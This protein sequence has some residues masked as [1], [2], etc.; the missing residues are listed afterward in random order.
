MRAIYKREL[1]SYFHS[2]IGFLFI[3]VTLF[4]LGLYFTVYNLMYGTPYF[5]YVV[6]SVIFLFLV[7]VPVL[8]MKILAEE[9]K[10]KT[11]QM[12]LTAPVTVGG[13]VMGKYLALLTIFAIPSVII[14]FYPLILTGFGTVPLGEAYLAILGFFLY[15]AA[16]IAIGL[17]IS[18]LT[19]SQ[20][21]AAV[22]TFAVLFLGYMMSSIS[23]LI[24]ST[25]NLLTKLL[26]CLDMYTPFSK[27]LN[28]TLNVGAV[29][30]FVSVIALVLF[31]TTQSIQKR[32]YSVSVKSLS[33]GAYNTGIIA[34]AV[35]VVVVVNIILGEMPGT[36]TA[37]DLTSEKLYSLT[38]QTKEFVKN[39]TEDVTI[40]VLVKEENE[41]TTLGQTLD[42]Y[43]DLSDHI[44]VEYVDPIVNPRFYTQFTDTAISTNS[45]IVVGSQRSKVIQSSDIYTTSFD[46]ET[47]SSTTT[48]YDGEGQITSAL[49]YVTSDDMPKIYMTEGHGEYT[50]SS[51]FINALAKENVD[52]ETV[53]LMNYDAVPEDAA[54]LLI[55]APE[56]D[57]NEDDK[58]KII[59]YLENGK[60]V[61][62]ITRYTNEDMTNFNAILE[63]MG[64]S[65]QDGMVMEQDNNYFYQSP[66]YLL[67]ETVSSV[68]TAGIHN[69]YYVFF[70]Y[71]QGIAIADEEAEGLTY[72]TFLKTSD[73]AFSK[74]DIGNAVDYSKSQ[75]DLDGPF[76]L[77]VE[78]VKEVENGTASMVVFG[79]S[80]LF[81]DSAD[82]MVSGANQ[83]LFT[84]AVGEFADH[85]V[86]VSIPVKSYEVSTLILTQANI[87]TLAL[88]TTVLLPVGCL[89][90]GFVIWFRRRK[91]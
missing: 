71:G 24:S 39:M 41:D 45:L 51:T 13:I 72:T 34:A 68:Y 14:C 32:R 8:T 6:S 19:E 58:D 18:S 66:L 49:A 82:E 26:D 63:Y 1:K 35:A 10:N 4:F 67:P 87:L 30:Y 44:T 29:V 12:I 31:L 78:A 80:E 52:Y 25:G 65:I 20:V 5:S 81:T 42:R 57:F 90:I 77:G 76:Y 79:S 48:G 64:L 69:Q 16:S 47:Y 33:L 40:Y 89:V 53:N 37:I 75:G 2:F 22:L 84:N 85:E 91:R 54:C 43:N 56:K 27:L 23:G 17:L 83:M 86:S 59:A 74:V 11:D 46:Y 7:S 88:I 70:P 9:K 28:G 50:L 60:R 38:D 3:G 73:S 61:M 55:N 15:G 21:I 36:W 62:L